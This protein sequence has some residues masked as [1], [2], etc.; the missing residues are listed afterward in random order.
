MAGRFWTPDAVTFTLAADVWVST[1]TGWTFTVG[2]FW[3]QDFGL[4]ADAVL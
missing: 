3:H 4:P 1:S 2:R